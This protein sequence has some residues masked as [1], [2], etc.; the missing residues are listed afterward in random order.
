MYF[1]TETGDQA[2]LNLLNEVLTLSDTELPERELVALKVEKMQSY[3]MINVVEDE[4]S[5]LENQ[6]IN[7]TIAYQDIFQSDRDIYEE[8]N[9][10]EVEEGVTLI[11]LTYPLWKEGLVVSVLGLLG[12][13]GMLTGL[14][15]SQKIKK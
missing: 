11:S 14:C 10:L 12:G 7:T 3:L 15:F 1:A 6:R 2:V 8:N 5:S 9:L 13:V 4:D